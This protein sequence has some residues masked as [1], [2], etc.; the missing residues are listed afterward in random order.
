MG[1]IT[2]ITIA[3]RRGVSGPRRPSGEARDH[4]IGNLVGGPHNKGG[5]VRDPRDDIA[6][7]KLLLTTHRYV[8]LGGHDQHWDRP[9][10]E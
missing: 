6:D 2:R 7:V 9:T 3:E 4:R 10:L 5:G 8:K 1:R